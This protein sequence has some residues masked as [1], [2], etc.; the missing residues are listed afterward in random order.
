MQG[1]PEFC[2]YRY[3][4]QPW[5]TDAPFPRSEVWHYLNHPEDC[6]TSAGAMDMLPIRIKGP[7]TSRTRAF[8]MHLEERYSIWAILLPSLLLATLVFVP[9]GW[10]ISDWLHQNPNDLQNATVPMTVAVSALTLVLNMLISLLMFR[11]TV[12]D[13]D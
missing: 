4:P 10:F 6:G 2:D 5:P 3:R 9:T 12:S 11:W 8:G 13:P 7:I 1:E